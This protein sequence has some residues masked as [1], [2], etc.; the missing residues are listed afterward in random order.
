MLDDIFERIAD[1]LSAHLIE[2]STDILFGQLLNQKLPS[3][4]IGTI[5][6]MYDPQLGGKITVDDHTFDFS[7]R[8]LDNQQLTDLKQLL[9]TGLRLD[10][11][12]LKDLI[13]TALTTRLEFLVRP[14]EATIGALFHRLDDS[15]SVNATTIKFSLSSISKLLSQWDPPTSTAI[16]IIAPYLQGLGEQ[17]IDSEALVQLLQS[18]IEKEL[19]SNPLPEVERV[20]NAVG[21]LLKEDDS[22][23]L[24]MVD[25]YDYVTESLSSRG[26]S[27][28]IASVEIEKTVNNDLLNIDSALHAL[29]R[30][31]LYKEIKLLDEDK[32]DLVVVEEEL[33]DFTQF[34]EEITE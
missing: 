5:K 18:T 27:S 23:D 31:K 4:L 14:A 26:L 32:E 21:G 24:A 10:S 1:N 20:L 6:L 19:S 25:V 17:E 8:P 16:N 22:S 12:E 7:E 9:Q 11:S 15:S 33:D 2:G 28:W 30:L 13:I 3:Y 34:I 29:Q